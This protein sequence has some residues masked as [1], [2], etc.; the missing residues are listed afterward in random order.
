MSKTKTLSDCQHDA[1][2]LAGLMEAVGHLANERELLSD[3]H[4]DRCR[5][6]SWPAASAAGRA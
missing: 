2:M 6:P 5:Q 3:N 1:V 4:P